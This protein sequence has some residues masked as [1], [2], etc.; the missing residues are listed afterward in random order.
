MIDLTGQRFGRLVALRRMVRSRLWR[1]KCDCG[2]EARVEQGNLRK[3]NTRSCGCLKAERTA[4]RFRTHGL[5]G[6]A[7]YGIYKEARKRC[8]QPT[9][10]AFKYYGGRGI[11]F[12][13]QNFVEFFAEVGPRP[14]KDLTLDRIDNNGHYEK[15]NL[16]WATRLQQAQ[17]RRNG[18]ISK[19]SRN[20]LSIQ[21]FNLLHPPFSPL[22]LKS[23]YFP[24]VLFPVQTVSRQRHVSGHSDD[25]INGRQTVTS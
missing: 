8:K 6:T 14:S 23:I 19:S 21:R 4:E 15:G 11:E 7:E 12:R 16:R 5:C 22:K 25:E 1:C 10:R 3:G 18:Q 20:S 24:V 13:F 17:N 9:N 2:K